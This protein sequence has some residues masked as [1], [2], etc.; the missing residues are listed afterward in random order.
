MLGDI[1]H[2]SP[3]SRLPC[4]LFS[5]ADFASSR[6]SWALRRCEVRTVNLAAAQFWGCAKVPNFGLFWLRLGAKFPPSRPHSQ[7]IKCTKCL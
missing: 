7:S 5:F 4:V 3:A 2:N 1:K 6:S